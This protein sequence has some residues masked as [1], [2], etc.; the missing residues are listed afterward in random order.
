MPS[1]LPTTNLVGVWQLVASQPASWEQNAPVFA[2]NVAN[3]VCKITWHPKKRH[4]Y[5]RLFFEYRSQDNIPLKRVRSVARPMEQ[6]DTID[7]VH[8]AC[9][10]YSE[11]FENFPESE[12]YWIVLAI[13]PRMLVMGL[14]SEGLPV[15]S[16]KRK[17]SNS[18]ETPEKDMIAQVLEE[19]PLLE[20]YDQLGV[21]L[22]Y[23]ILHSQDVRLWD[24]PMEATLREYS[25][26]PD[27]PIYLND[28]NTVLTD[29]MAVVYEEATMGHRLEEIAPS[30]TCL[31]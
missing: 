9:F 13:T 24:E 6:I 27:N 28:L 20:N 23:R 30:A 11:L 25:L 7:S 3:V 31:V 4:V 21:Y 22:F 14:Y 26:Y 16:K 19:H 8:S 29:E 5:H 18:S 1:N 2:R 10:E 12:M 15:V 17:R